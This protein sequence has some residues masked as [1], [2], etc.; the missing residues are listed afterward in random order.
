MPAAFALEAA[1]QSQ[2][3]TSADWTLFHLGVIHARINWLG[4]LGLALL[5]VI[6]VNVW[7]GVPFFAISLLAGLQTINPE[8]Q[9]AA[10]I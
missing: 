7:R 8:L 6:I 2:P 9:E 10:A 4:Y 1:V 3:S 5:S